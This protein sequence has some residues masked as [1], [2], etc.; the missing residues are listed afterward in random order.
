MNMYKTINSNI[1]PGKYWGVDIPVLLGDKDDD[2]DTIFII[3]ESP[4]RNKKD[5]KDNRDLVIGTPFAVACVK[6]APKQCDIYKYIFNR[7]INKGYN[8]YIT[9]AV[10]VW[11][12]GMKQKGFKNYIN[13][14]FLEK[15]IRKINPTIIVTWG[16]TALKAYGKKENHFHQTHPG[17]QKW[18]YWEKEMYKESLKDKKPKM[19]IG[20]EYAKKDKGDRV[21]YL[22]YFISQKIIDKLEKR[23]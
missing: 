4:T 3:G 15:E 20:Y 14:A 23:H 2:N 6:G 19:T 21:Q 5:F 18:D 17:T 16:E 7:L 8:V 11:Y 12:D 13:P 22:A 10:K 1:I 9:D